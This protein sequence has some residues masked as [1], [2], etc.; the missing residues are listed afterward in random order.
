VTAPGGGE[1]RVRAVVA[2]AAEALDG[3]AVRRW[4]RGRLGDHKVPRE[5][6]IVPS[7]SLVPATTTL[8]PGTSFTVVASST[9]TGTSG[10]TVIVCD[11]PL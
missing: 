6:L 3:E 5:V 1:P 9:V 4:C 10:G 8:A 2:C 7:A 11:P